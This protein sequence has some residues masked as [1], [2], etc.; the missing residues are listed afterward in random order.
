M[1]FDI[2]IE[3]L[4]KRESKHDTDKDMYHLTFKTYNAEITGKFERSELRHM[5][6]QLDNAIV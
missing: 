3:Y 4:G 5:I 6:E 1:K 2:K